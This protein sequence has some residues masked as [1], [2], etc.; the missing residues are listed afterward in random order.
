MPYTAGSVSAKIELD[1]SDFDNK[2]KQLQ[3]KVDSLKAQLQNNGLMDVNKQLK[4]VQEQ[5][6]QST[7]KIEDLETKCKDYKK[8]LNNLRDENKSLTKEIKNANNELKKSQTTLDNVKKSV[9]NTV[10]SH[11]SN[12]DAIKTETKAVQDNIKII[13]QETKANEKLAASKKKTQKLDLS[14][15]TKYSYE[16][17]WDNF[18]QLPK[19]YQTA[20]EGID[21]TLYRDIKRLSYGLTDEIGEGLKAWGKQIPILDESPL[22]KLVMP[23]DIDKELKKNIHNLEKLEKMFGSRKS[24]LDFN[25]GAANFQRIEKWDLHNTLKEL[26]QMEIVPRKAAGEVSKLN[27]ELSKVGKDKGLDAEVKST[28]KLNESLKKTE[29]QAK[30]TSAQYRKVGTD[31]NKSFT[32]E[33]Y[34]TIAP[35]SG[36]SVE[37][38]PVYEQ[39]KSQFKPLVKSRGEFDKLWSDALMRMGASLYPSRDPEKFVKI[40][41]RNFGYIDKSALKSVEEVKK[42]FQ[43]VSKE[44][45]KA[46]VEATKLNNEVKKVGKGNEVKTVSQEVKELTSSE[47]NAEKETAK[48]SNQLKKL[49]MS[50]VGVNNR[51][52]LSDRV[53][54]FKEIQQRVNSI[55]QLSNEEEKAGK[56]AAKLDKEVSELG[57]KNNIPRL[58]EPIIELTEEEEKAVKETAKL[59]KE[60]ENIGDKNNIPKLVEPLEELTNEEKKAT[61]EAKKLNNELNKG[62]QGR[63]FTETGKQLKAIREAQRAEGYVLDAMMVKRNIKGTKAADALNPFGMPNAEVINFYRQW[64]NVIEEIANK[65]IKTQNIQNYL[66]VWAEAEITVKRTAS[67]I[68]KA[69]AKFSDTG[70]S[71]SA[72]QEFVW[73]LRGIS[74]TIKEV[75]TEFNRFE[76][77]TNEIISRMTRTA[78]INENW[79]KINN[80]FQKTQERLNYV[81]QGYNKLTDS[82]VR[83]TQVLNTFNFKLLEGIDR[84]S[85]FYQRTTHLASA[86]WK[87]NSGVGTRGSAT[88]YQGRQTVGGYS[89]YLSQITKVQEALEKLNNAST[90]KF[91][92]QMVALAEA[93]KKTGAEMNAFSNKAHMV[94]SSMDSMG[95]SNELAGK[96]SRISREL[97]HFSSISSKNKSALAKLSQQ[98]TI[99]R[100]KLNVLETAFKKGEITAQTY[101]SEL[102]KL[103]NKLKLLGSSSQ[104]AIRELSLGNSELTKTGVNARNTGRGLTSFNNG[105]TQTAHSGRI[106]SNTLYQIRGA[107]LSLKM[108]FTAMGGMALWGFASQIAEGIKTTVTAKNEMEAQLKQNDKV[109]EGGIKYFRKELDKLTKTYKKVNKYSIGETVS[110]IGL[111]FDLT[112][113]QMKDALPIVTMIQ[114]EYVRAGRKS[115]EAALAV[116]DI[117]QGEFQRLSRETG[118]GKEELVAYGWD[119]DKTNIDG[120]LK[121]L[122]KAALD[123][124]WDVF[125]KKATSLN[126]VLTITQSRFEETGADLLDSASPMIV[127]AFNMI[128]G[129][130]DSVSTSFNSLNSFWRSFLWI[131]G[132]GAL[133]GGI[134]TALPMVT[135]GMGLVDIATIGWSKSVATAALNLNKLEVAQYGLRKAIAATISGTQAGA[136]A[137]TRWSKAIMGRILGLN[138]GILAERGYKSAIFNRTVALKNGLDVQKAHI[139]LG[140]ASVLNLETMKHSEMGRAQ[141]LAYMTNNLKLSEAAEL[142]RGKAILKTAT[143]WKVLGLAIRGVMAIGIVAWLSSMAVQADLVKKRVEAFNE[144]VETGSDK[145]KEAKEESASYQKIMDKYANATSK[146]DKNKYAQAK[147]NKAIVDGNVKEL[148][149]ANKLAKS[150]KAQ[151]DEREKSIK[152]AQSSFRKQNL[153]AAGHSE[154][155]ATEKQAFWVDKINQAQYEITN[156]Y[157]KQYDWLEAS[158]KHI[159]ENLEHMNETNR[160][161]KD[162]DKYIM[163]YST[164]AEEAGEHLKQFYQGDLMAGAYFAIDNLKL[165]WIDIWNNDAFLNF[166]KAVQKTWDDLKPTAYAIK[167]AL[168]GIGEALLNFF[169]TESGRWVFAI[170]A[171]GTGLG[172][173]GLKIGKWVSGSD[174]VFEVLKKVGGKLKDVAKGWKDVKDNAEDAIEKTGGSTSTSTGG[175]NGDV[176]KTKAKTP[177]KETLKSDAQNYARAA[178]GIVA[179]MLLITEAIILL[180]APMWGLAEVGKQF[181]AQE[182]EIQAGIEG[183]KMISPVLA[184]LLPAVVGL[185]LIMD[186]YAPSYTQIV[187]GTLKAAIGIVAGMLLVA[188]TIVMIIP[189]IWAI[190]ALGDQYSGIQA[191]VQKGTQAMKIVSDSLMY[192]APFIPAL[193]LAIA[194]VAIAFANPILGA[195]M[196][197][198]ITLGIPI[199]MLWVAETI[200]SLEYPLQQ[201]GALGDKFTDLS[202]VQQG[203]EAIKLTAEAL[204]YVEQAMSAFALIAWDSLATAVANLIGVKI[205]ADLTQLTG[206]GGFFSQLETFITDFNKLE[207]TQIDSAKVTTLSESATGIDSVKTALVTVKEALKDLPNFETDTR[208]PNEKYQDAVSGAATADTNGVT[209]YFEQL[210]QPIDQLNEFVKNFNENIT[211]EP[212]NPDKVAALQN[213]A[214]GISAIQTA[215]DAVKNAMGS[216]VDASWQGNMASGGILGAAV[217]Y[218]IGD[219]NPQA[220]GL[221]SGLDE[222][223][224]SVKDIMNFNTKINGLTATGSGDTSG[225]TNASNVVSALQTQINN[226]KTTLTGAIPTV[227][228]TAKNMGTA[229]VSGVKEGLTSLNSDVSS[230]LTGLSDTMSSKGKGL[231]EKLSNGFKDNA[232][233]KSTVETEVGYALQYLDERKQDFYD[234]GA[235]LGTSLSNGF[236]D[237]NG[238][239]QHSPGKMARAVSDEMGYIGQALTNTGGLNLP[240]MASQLAQSLTTNFN[241][242]FGLGNIQL[243]NLDQFKQSISTILPTV[244]GMKSQ[245]V[246]NFNAMKTG[247]QSSFTNI[248]A[249][250]RSSLSNM[251]AATIGNIGNIKTSWRGMQDA[252]IASADHIK[253]QTGQKINKLKSN[254]GE[255]WNKIKHPDQLI[256]SQGGHTGS[257]RRRFTGGRANGHYAGGT[258]SRSQS[259]F[260]GRRSSGQPSDNSMLEYLKCMMETGKPCYAGGWNFNWTNKISKKF[261]GWNTHFGAYHLD[262]FLNVGKFENSNFPVKGRADVAKQ[263]IFDVIRATDYDK[264]FDS[265]FGDDPVAALRAGAFNCWDGTNIVLA[266]ARAFGFEGSRGHGTWN[267]IGHV[268]ANI[269]GLGIIDP[270]A[271]QNRGSFTSSAV[272]GYNAGSMPRRYATKGDVP[273]N[274]GD[275]YNTNIEINVHGNDVEVNNKRID[276]RS[277]K[278]ILDILGINPATGN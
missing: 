241:P 230:A 11:K 10:K 61:T 93:L 234:R 120:L 200:W 180:K 97:S 195:I 179:G 274:G 37:L 169:G 125:A 121:A 206:E 25:G 6:K 80:T 7:T 148:E 64:G 166:W 29:A 35:M 186:K 70:R 212:I 137:E 190:G 160:T 269:P 83:T 122:K 16:E 199:G 224:M 127:E 1:T 141:K 255:F 81:T 182:P 258:I 242:T 103:A 113:K 243:P 110:S 135:K 209:N 50:N 211:V 165:L 112:A 235:A 9:D 187:T 277:G 227:K 178:I 86:M 194:T 249:K 88:E 63:H 174:S 15:K 215:I 95:M 31:L 201:I 128:I 145:L 28:E 159:S 2:V 60:V 140:K 208:S 115:E 228:A 18:D 41:G 99:Y 184:V 104:Q 183:L 237:N 231:G 205:G 39:L 156:S 90:E 154:T 213:S 43:E 220:S 147:A 111:E 71:V 123:R 216:A 161:Q 124:H 94:M 96:L 139:N 26:E 214:N 276:E 30:K 157:N 189:S 265:N 36:R 250:T 4:E 164:V 142:S 238:L 163:E 202:N 133:F 191:Q 262:D 92:E 271:I 59:D 74:N 126:D 49:R 85:I 143:S 203:A 261:K 58:V 172:L 130:I 84:E 278:Q 207:I 46:T 48:L 251:K 20:L 226:T 138:Q 78:E 23:G 176:D 167:D 12:A 175:I 193:A 129:A 245:V 253:T 162:M 151:N 149:T 8:Q 91:K 152:L 144:I 134:L 68:D 73:A 118:V 100:D 106:L 247:I 259:L 270:T 256:G 98:T 210:K 153:M 27:S 260:K 109:G 185:S 117:L 34:K 244:T 33:L 76:S 248:V 170:G 222:L 40:A 53:S 51:G 246:T 268:W 188:E 273:T 136:L 252:L 116:K 69:I 240:Q 196:G 192:L 102:T 223:Y 107:L 54:N 171:L 42:S 65:Q 181:K 267:G 87:L 108:I 101:E 254:L 67:E 32:K 236:K 55:K 19:K 57:D 82:M 232:K 52:T 21:R 263:Y 158:S 239:D 13:N 204:G 219:G 75:N 177:F 275:T 146:E 218:L 17:L 44:E 22:R 257:I 89:N 217:G 119:E 45:S 62:T 173:I 131:G 79:T 198:A 264:Y 229:I 150:Y 105:V 197:T 114:S 66:K 225:V 5:L 24:A 38:K 272:K 155:E 77:E 14:G 132:G 56:A 266:I 3:S 47:K 72:T 168:V 221:K 233:I